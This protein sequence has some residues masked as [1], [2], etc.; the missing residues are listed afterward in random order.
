MRCMTKGQC[1]WAKRGGCFQE[2]RDASRKGLYMTEKSDM[3][4]GNTKMMSHHPEDRY[5]SW[6]DAKRRIFCDVADLFWMD[7]EEID[8]EQ[9]KLLGITIGSPDAIAVLVDVSATAGTNKDWLR[10]DADKLPPSRVRVMSLDMLLPLVAEEQG[11]ESCLKRLVAAEKKRIAK[12][13]SNR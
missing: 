7:S 8:S 12:M 1:S 11:A 13:H 2:M 9:N 3:K 4:K 5:I 6:I 10:W